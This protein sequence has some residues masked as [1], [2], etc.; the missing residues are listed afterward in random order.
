MLILLGVLDLLSALSIILIKF[1]DFNIIGWIAAIYLFVKGIVFF[2]ITSL[3]DIFVGVII[4]FAV[5]GF[6][7]VWTWLAFIWLVQKA[8][9]SFG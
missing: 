4:L 8:L 5:Y 6:F 1:F 9:F 2:S 3:V 7:G